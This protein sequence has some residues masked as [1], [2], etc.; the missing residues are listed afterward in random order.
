MWG[1]E[2]A[3]EVDDEEERGQEDRPTHLAR[4]EAQPGEAIER[5]QGEAQQDHQ[6]QPG[7]DRPPEAAGGE[8]DT[9]PG[10]ID[11]QQARATERDRTA[12]EAAGAR[13]E[14]GDGGDQI[15]QEDDRPELER[16]LIRRQQHTRVAS[17]HNLDALHHHAELAAITGRLEGA[18]P[19]FDVQIAIA[20]RTRRHLDRV[21]REAGNER[22]GLECGAIHGDRDDGARVGAPREVEGQAVSATPEAREA[23]DALLGR[24]TVVAEFGLFGRI[25][26]ELVG[27]VVGEHTDVDGMT[28]TNLI[29]P[30]EED[31]DEDDQRQE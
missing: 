4:A 2:V 31:G 6:D 19:Q 15:G 11:E 18:A 29:D 3:A 24:P 27:L 8:P 20:H 23:D 28:E 30:E 22:E 25:E 17:R 14:P 1:V 16:R 21:R 26:A 7:D 13:V 10:T 9:E 12:D 5:R